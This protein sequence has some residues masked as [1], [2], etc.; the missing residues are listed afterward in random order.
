[1]RN[2]MYNFRAAMAALAIALAGIGSSDAFAQASA[3]ATANSSA[4]IANPIAITNTAALNFGEIVAG[5]TAATVVVTAAAAP[6]RTLAGAAD[7]FLVTSAISS[8]AFNIS[9][10]AAATFAVTLPASATLTSGANTMTVNTFTH[11]L[12]A[13]PTLP[14]AASQPLAMYVGGTLNV[15]ASQA[16]GTYNGSFSVT[17]AYN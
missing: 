9:G 15:G 7:A 12:G 10:R 17:V 16:A 11:S 2:K 6:T 1:M 8:A 4:V 14:A 3:T 13:T 5:S